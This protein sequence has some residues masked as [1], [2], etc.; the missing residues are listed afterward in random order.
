MIHQLEAGE[1]VRGCRYTGRLGRTMIYTKADGHGNFHFHYADE[2]P[3]DGFWVS[4]HFFYR[5]MNPAPQAVR[6][7]E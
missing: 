3:T 2:K 5:W 4:E 7:S 1:P 6:V